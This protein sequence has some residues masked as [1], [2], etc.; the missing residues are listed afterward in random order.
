MQEIPSA[1][2]GTFTHSVRQTPYNKHMIGADYIDTSCGNSTCDVNVNP[3]AHRLTLTVFHN[4]AVLAEDS[5]YV[6]AIREGECYMFLLM[7][8]HFMCH[9]APF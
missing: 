6:P 7:I 3:E 1:C 8:W 4:E 5:V 9:S 2:Q